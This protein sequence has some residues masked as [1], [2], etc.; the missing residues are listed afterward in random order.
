MQKDSSSQ[1]DY[2]DIISLLEETTEY[3]KKV[4]EEVSGDRKMT[5]SIQKTLDRDMKLLEQ[6]KEQQNNQ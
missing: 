5:I 6:F 4:L 1:I 3:Y 2:S